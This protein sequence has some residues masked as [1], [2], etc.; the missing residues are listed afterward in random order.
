MARDVA[1]VQKNFSLMKL[2]SSV[3]ILEP[4]CEYFRIHPCFI[5]A[6]LKYSKLIGINAFERPRPG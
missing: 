3:Q 1:H 4:I 6:S 2:H 5:I